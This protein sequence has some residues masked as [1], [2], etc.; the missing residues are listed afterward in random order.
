MNP[1]DVAALTMLL[2]V[3]KQMS[4][5]PFGVII[6]AMVIGPWLFAFIFWRMDNRRFLMQAETNRA[7][8]DETLRQYRQDVSEIKRLYESNS[9]LVVATNEA[10]KRLEKIYGET[11]SVIALNTQTQ[12]NLAKTVETNVK[13]IEDNRFCPMSGPD[14]QH[15]LNE[16]KKL[17]TTGRLT[18]EAG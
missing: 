8:V 1:Q 13:A 17:K 2:S 9:R 15:V 11:V 14:L 7:Q 6:F 18:G 12:T 16:Y 3:L 10:F 5:W 4:T